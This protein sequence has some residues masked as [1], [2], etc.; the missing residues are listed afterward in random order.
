MEIFL[1]L[2]LRSTYSL[3]VRTLKENDR[4]SEQQQQPLGESSSSPTDW[5]S[6][7]RRREETRD[8][9]HSASSSNSTRALGL[10]NKPICW[11]N[12]EEKHLE[13]FE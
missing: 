8:T 12:P 7:R 2:F 5:Q 13:R 1:L 3:S 10:A 4:S 9:T 6:R 11:R